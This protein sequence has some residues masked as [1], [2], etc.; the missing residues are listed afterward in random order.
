MDEIS[1]N[2]TTDKKSRNW[3]SKYCRS[4]KFKSNAYQPMDGNMAITELTS[5]L[6]TKNEL[7]IV[8]GYLPPDCYETNA[9]Q[10]I[11]SLKCNGKPFF[12]DYGQY[13]YDIYWHQTSVGNDH[14][15]SDKH[16]DLMYVLRILFYEQNISEMTYKELD[17]ILKV[18]P[19]SYYE[20][21]AN[22]T[23]YSFKLNG[24]PF[25]IDKRHYNYSE[26]TFE[27][28]ISHHLY[29]SIE[30][31]NN[32]KEETDIT[33]NCSKA[34]GEKFAE[35]SRFF[36]IRIKSPSNWFSYEI[37][38]PLKYKSPKSSHTLAKRIVYESDLMI[39]MISSKEAKHILNQC[40]E[41][42]FDWCGRS[43]R[44]KQLELKAKLSS[45]IDCD[46]LSKTLY[47]ICEA[48][49]PNDVNHNIKY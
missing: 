12:I 27:S 32:I 39:Q 3:F 42:L 30:S 22:K 21:N 17:Y 14:Y 45:V 47:A 48:I 2:Q 36:F 29:K 41:A 13:N 9:N 18:L 31:V 34:L 49:E 38:S 11:Y 40:K 20:L 26:Y 4:F 44:R 15:F 1:V 24:K 8:L 28:K 16:T 43:E 6:V 35:K 7:D 23:I 37:E 19:K 5:K 25:F 10:T 46:L 33:M